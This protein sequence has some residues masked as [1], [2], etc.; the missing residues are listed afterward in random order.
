MTFVFSGRRY[1]LSGLIANGLRRTAL[2]KGASP[3]GKTCFFLMVAFFFTFLFLP[4][5]FYVILIL[6]LTMGFYNF[7]DRVNFNDTFGRNREIK[8]GGYSES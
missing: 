6:R 8:Y 7:P 2:D 3:R 1:I 4:S 5:Q